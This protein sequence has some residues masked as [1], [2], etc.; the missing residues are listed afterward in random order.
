MPEP[1]VLTK[2]D[3]EATHKLFDE[4][5]KVVE[6]KDSQTSEAKTKIEKIEKDFEALDKKNQDFVL[7]QAADKK[8]QE[9]LKEQVSD[10]EKKLA[11]MPNGS[12]GR[13]EATVEMK[14]FQNFVR[15]GTPNGSGGGISAEEMKALRTDSDV[16]GGYLA[17]PEY[18]FEIIKK[19][20]EISPIRAYARVRKTSRGEIEIPK[21]TSIP[22]ANFRAEGATIGASQ[23]AYGML[24]IPAQHLDALVIA[25]MTMLSDSGF[26][27][28]SEINQDVV[29]AFSLAE[30][31][32]FIT[33][34]LNTQPEGILTNAAVQVVNSGVANDIVADNFYDLQ[35]QVKT[36]YNPAFIFNRRTL[37]RVRKMKDGVG[38]YLFAPAAQGMPNTIG[39]DPFALMPAMPDI[40]AGLTPVAYGD[41]GRGYTIVDGINMAIVRDPF[42]LSDQGKIRFVFSRRVGGKVTLDEAIKKLTCSTA[43]WTQQ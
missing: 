17:P 16:E 7:G 36:G 28:E 32:A 34:S 40:G 11:R 6:S 43:G 21:R 39:G 13:E 2:K 23:S 27:M 26:N 37:A 8:A 20:T 25:T 29:E 33:G 22:T 19:I 9:E 5:K 18:V 15:K 4:L 24:K 42:T 12:K 10:L 35:G 30:G 14:A 1:E 3:I 31:N 38:Q 41:W